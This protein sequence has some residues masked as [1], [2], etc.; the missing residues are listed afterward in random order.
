MQMMACKSHICKPTK[1]DVKTQQTNNLRV[2]FLD[3]NVKEILPLKVSLYAANVK[4]I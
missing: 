4:N 3:Q 1:S 2:R